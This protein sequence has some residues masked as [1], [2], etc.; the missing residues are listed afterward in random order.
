MILA[1]SRHNKYSILSRTQ[2]LFKKGLPVAETRHFWFS[3]DKAHR[4]GDRSRLHAVPILEGWAPSRVSHIWSMGGALTIASAVSSA[5]RWPS[6]QP[7]AA[8]RGSQV[9]LH[10]IWQSWNW[11]T[12]MGN[13]CKCFRKTNTITPHR[14]A[15]WKAL[16][17]GRLV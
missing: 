4:K 16:C 8:F 11:I 17:L 7:S 15:L 6:L 13:D 3:W 5:M 12:E 1:H 2:D 14:S 10:C 9:M